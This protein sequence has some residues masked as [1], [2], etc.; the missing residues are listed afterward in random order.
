MAGGIITAAAASVAGQLVGAFDELLT[1]DDERNQAKLK[2]QELL[3]QPQLL[4]AMTTLK[5]AEHPS[6]FVAGARPGLLWVCV[7]GLAWEYVTRPLLASA[8]IMFGEV[9]KA[10]ELPHLNAEQLIGLVSILLG[11]AGYRS[12]EKSR[13][14]ARETL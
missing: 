3:M 10:V 4:Q 1:S 6:I 5:E 2:M 9:A 8:L 13:G 12:F 14:I 11:L 7:V